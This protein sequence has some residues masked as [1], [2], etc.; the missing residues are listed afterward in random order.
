MAAPVTFPSPPRPAPAI[1]FAGFLVASAAA[2]AAVFV[3]QFGFGLAP[4]ILC[5]WQRVPHA[6]AILLAG[7]GIGTARSAARMRDPGRAAP[8]RAFMALAVL[9]LLTYLAGSGLA[10][11]HVGVEQHWWA[12]TEACTGGAGGG[13]STEQLQAQLLGTA[14]AHCDQ[15]A[16]SLFDISLAGYNFILS[17]GLSVGAAWALLRFSRLRRKAQP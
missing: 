9:L 12:G 14:P 3:M 7:I 1:V 16:W 5:I 11:F 15:I 13:L 2:L 4:C 8:W 10:A 6:V 17:V